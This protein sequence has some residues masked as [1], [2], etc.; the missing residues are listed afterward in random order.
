[1]PINLA[2]QPEV[3]TDGKPTQTG[4][5]AKDMALGQRHADDHI[6]SQELKSRSPIHFGIKLNAIFIRQRSREAILCP[7]SMSCMSDPF[8]SRHSWSRNAANTA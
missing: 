8:V 2:R 5:T 7:F 6:E 3:P 1:L 4:W